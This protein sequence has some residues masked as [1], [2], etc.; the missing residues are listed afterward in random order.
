MQTTGFVATAIFAALVAAPAVAVTYD[1]AADFTTQ[2]GHGGFT[3]GSYDTATGMFTAFDSNTNCVISSVVCL[4]STSVNLPSAFMGDGSATQS[5][6][7]ILTPGKLIVHPGQG[8]Q[9]VYVRWTASA[10]GGYIFNAEFNQQDSNSAANS[11]GITGLY[12]SHFIVDQAHP[13]VL[14]ASGFAIFSAGESLTFIID[15]NG[16]YSYDSTG[17]SFDVTSVPEPASWA[18]MMTGFAIA[19]TALRRRGTATVAA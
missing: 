17:V 8:T 7:V 2:Q 16:D 11:V 12:G 10:P 19:G 13:D 18:L 14:V 6:T 3:Y 1:A 5:G 4:R 9:S 15:K